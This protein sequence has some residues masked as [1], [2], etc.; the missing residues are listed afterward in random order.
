VIAVDDESG[1]RW[2]QFDIARLKAESR[3]GCVTPSAT[4]ENFGLL[5]QL[6]EVECIFVSDIV[7][8]NDGKVELKLSVGGIEALLLALGAHEDH[9]V[10]EVRPIDHSIFDLVFGA[11]DRIEF[12]LNLRGDVLKLQGSHHY[13]WMDGLFNYT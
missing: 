5:I 11:R 2:I 9:H 12:L 1:A 7:E 13:G 3:F 10:V 6:V 8:G 4:P